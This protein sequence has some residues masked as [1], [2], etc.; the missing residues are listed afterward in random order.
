MVV[1]RRMSVCWVLT[2]CIALVYVDCPEM[3]RDGKRLGA[4]MVQVRGG[5]HLHMIHSYTDGT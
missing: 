1:E 2:L 3:V 4:V 5:P